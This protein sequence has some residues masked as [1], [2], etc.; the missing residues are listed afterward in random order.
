MKSVGEERQSDA[1]QRA[2]DNVRPGMSI[3]HRS[4]DGCKERSDERSSLRRRE[5]TKTPI[6]VNTYERSSSQW[7]NDNP[8]FDLQ[9]LDAEERG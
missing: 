3:I 9:I 5:V 7:S 6:I 4:A 8:G 2:R 1:N